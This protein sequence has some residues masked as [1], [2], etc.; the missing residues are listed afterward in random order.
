MSDTIQANKTLLAALYT[1]QSEIQ[2]VKKD[3][4]NPHFKSKYATLD[5]I[6]DAVRDTVH[7]AGL[8][9]SNSVWDGMVVT[10]ISEVKS[11]ESMES[12]FPIPPALLA[13]PQ[14]VGSALTYARRYNLCALLQITTGE[15]DDGNQASTPQPPAKPKPS[16]SAPRCTSPDT[17]PFPPFEKWETMPTERLVK[18][19]SC[20]QAPMTQAHRDCINAIISLRNS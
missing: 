4:V 19:A 1:V 20:T 17:C 5:G 3:A 10:I 8:V 16:E 18:A 11:G 12:R 9:V 14:Q 13:N 2:K 6:W 15:D 7:K